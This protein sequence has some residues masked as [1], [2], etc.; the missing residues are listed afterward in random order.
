MGRPGGD[1]TWRLHWLEAEGGLQ[2]WREQVAS[3]IEAARIAV[4]RHVGTLPLDILV[5]FLRGAVIPELGIGGHAH[6]KSLLTLT[7]DPGNPHFVQSLN[8]GALRRTVAHEVHHCLRMARLGYGRTLG[9]A[10]VSEGLAGHFTGWLFGNPP[11]PWECAL[12]EDR[13]RAHW[14]DAASL[15]DDA[16]DH[17]SWFY[18][19]GGHRPRWLG[20]SLGYA[21]V[22]RWVAAAGPISGESWID[23]HAGTVLEAAAPRDIRVAGSGR[24]P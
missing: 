21:M 4:S 3:E 24:G 5:Q 23:V 8:D 22:G 2:P 15:D 10:L 7:L 13:L 9:E 18:G 12:D 19:T 1:E 14:P 17:N 16:Y 11:E 20:Y 6:R